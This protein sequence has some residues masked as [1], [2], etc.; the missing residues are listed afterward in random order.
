MYSKPT[1]ALQTTHPPWKHYS[2]L[3]VARYKMN[4]TKERMKDTQKQYAKQYYAVKSV[5]D[6]E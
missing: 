6:S 3:T 2:Q 1:E 4:I 5:T